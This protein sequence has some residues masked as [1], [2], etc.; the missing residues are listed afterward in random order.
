MSEGGRGS[1]VNVSSILGLVGAGSF[2]DM[3]EIDASPYV[4]AKHG[5]VGLTRT[6]AITYAKRG[7]RVNCVCPGYIRTPMIQALLDNDSM[8]AGLEALH[9]MGRVGEAEE[10]ANAIAFLASDE[11]SFITGAVLTVD[12]GYTAQ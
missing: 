5:I 12:G 11:A 10:V 6:F 1:I 9:P 8:R 7:V 2:P 3:P 4:A